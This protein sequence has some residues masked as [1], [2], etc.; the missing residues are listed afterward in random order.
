[1]T[2]TIRE[3]TAGR[4]FAARDINNLYAVRESTA[5]T[6]LVEQY[7]AETSADQ[8][9]KALTEKLD[10]Y[11]TNE[12]SSDVRGLEAK[13]MAAGRNDLLAAAMSQKEAAHK[14]IMMQQ[15]S[16]SAQSIYRFVLA[17]IVVNFEMAVWPL[18]QA[19]ASREIVDAAMLSHVI[20]PA[21]KILED[22]PLML[23]KRDIQGLIYFLAG[24][25]YIRW[26]TNVD[27]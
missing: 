19:K 3:N 2:T 8:T 7:N 26:D 22:N 18:V 27:I 1:M 12:T 20:S 24:N 4:D 21:F 6:R 9:L 11:F 13:L 25:C 16:R 10:H 15:S 14:A 17:E 5:M 23:D